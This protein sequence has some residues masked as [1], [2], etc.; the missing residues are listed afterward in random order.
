MLIQCIGIGNGGTAPNNRLAGGL[1]ESLSILCT[2][3][4]L[5]LRSLSCD[6]G[7]FSQL[8]VV[9]TEQ[10]STSS[11]HAMLASILLWHKLT[12]FSFLDDQTHRT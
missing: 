7:M 9:R 12:V 5:L 1:Y 3:I 10:R 8:A 11:V 2:E 4:L 6:D